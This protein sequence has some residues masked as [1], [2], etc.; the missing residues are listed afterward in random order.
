[1]KSRNWW[2]FLIPGQRKRKKVKKRR[3][4]KNLKKLNLKISA[5]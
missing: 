3:I 1:M 2:I 5:I 4:L